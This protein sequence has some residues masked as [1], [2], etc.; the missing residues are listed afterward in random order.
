MIGEG[1]PDP[2]DDAALAARLFLLSPARFGGMVLRGAS[3]ARDALVAR[4]QEAFA[5]SGKPCRRLPGHVDDERLLGGVDIATSL[6]SGTAVHARGLL[7][8]CA[9]GALIVPIAERVEAGVAGRLA[10]ALDGG[11]DWQGIP[12]ALI[13]LDDAREADDA[14]PAS[15]TERCAFHCDLAA[16]RRWEVEPLAARGDLANVAAPDDEALAALA[17][18]A[19]ALG[20]AS[21]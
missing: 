17:A 11:L 13:L 1:S 10:Q 15:L 6:A 3:P 8:E 16:S 2:L 9:G 19:H 14:P 7:E 4:L 5:A 12:P 21:V 20:V 18:T